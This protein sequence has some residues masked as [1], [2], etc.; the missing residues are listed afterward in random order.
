MFS[1]NNRLPL[2]VKE[3][4]AL[5][6]TDNRFEISDIV[7]K[8]TLVML[9]TDSFVYDVYSQVAFNRGQVVVYCP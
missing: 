9:V 7:T 4:F 1:T 6:T 8:S 2:L 3:T 5:F